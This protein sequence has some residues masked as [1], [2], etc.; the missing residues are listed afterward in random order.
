MHEAREGNAVELVEHQC[1]EPAR[2]QSAAMNLI[3]VPFM[4]DAAD[5]SEGVPITSHASPR[6]QPPIGHR[7]RQAETAPLSRLFPPPQALHTSSLRHDSF[8]YIVSRFGTRRVFG[9]IRADQKPSPLPPGRV[10]PAAWCCDSVRGRALQ[11]AELWKLPK[12]HF[13]RAWGAV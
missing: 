12:F 11:E 5:G 1:D 8:L 9:E 7:Q 3:D 2:Q 10:I 6:Q 13:R 4:N